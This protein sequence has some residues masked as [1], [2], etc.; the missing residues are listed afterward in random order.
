MSDRLMP[1]IQVGEKGK[2][3]KFRRKRGCAAEFRTVLL[4]GRR[5]P[6]AV[7]RFSDEVLY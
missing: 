2:K 6:K 5:E 1:T 3:K 7:V 4:T